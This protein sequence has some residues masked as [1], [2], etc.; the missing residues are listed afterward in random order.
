M[1][2]SDN[3]KRILQMLAEG[4]INID[5]AQRLLSLVNDRDGGENTPGSNG[6][7]SKS[8]PRYIHVIVEPRAG[9][10]QNGSFQDRHSKVNIRVPLSLIRAGMKFATLMPSETAEHI[11]K[12]LK[13]KGLSFNVKHLKEEDMQELISALQDSVINI[14]NEKE[15]IRIYSE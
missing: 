11:D 7:G 1:K 2:M 13:E 6:Q 5:E 3:Q 8:L 10:S 9:E 12:A 4:K 15:L 14:D